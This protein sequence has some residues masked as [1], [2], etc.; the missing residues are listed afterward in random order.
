MKNAVRLLSM[1]ALA[2][3][4]GVMPAQAQFTLT[5]IAAAK[6]DADADYYPDR[7]TTVFQVTGRIVSPSFRT[8][9]L[10]I[11]I[12]D[13][14]NGVG[15]RVWYNVPDTPDVVVEDYVPGKQVVAKGVIGQSNGVRFIRAQF[16]SWVS[17][18]DPTI[19]PV[20]PLNRTLAQLAAA[21]EDHEGSLVLVSNCWVS[22]GSLPAWQG[23]GTLTVTDLTG[24]VTLYIDADLDLDGQATP[25]ESFDLLGV[26]A[27]YDN[28]TPPDGG[29]QIYP[30]YY[31]DFILSTGDHTPAVS[32][33]NS[34]LYSIASGESLTV[35]VIG[36]DLDAADTLTL[37]L[38]QGPEGASFTDYGNRE[39]R[40]AW[41]PGAGDRGIVTGAVFEVTDGTSTGTASIVIT[42]LDEIQANIVLN[43]VHWDPANGLDGDA[44]GDGVRDAKY[45]EFIEILN[46]NTQA[47][48][49]TGWVLRL[50]E[51]A[52]LFTFP[53]CI[54]SAQSAVV[55]FGGG[56]NL[57][58]AFGQATVFST[59][60]TPGLS[61]KP[62]DRRLTLHDDGGIQIFSE[63]YRSFG[64]PNQSITRNPDGTGEFEEHLTANPMLRFSPGTK[65]DGGYFPGTGVTNAPPILA[66]IENQSAS[67][68]GVLTVGIVGA[69]PEEQPVTLSVTGAPSTAVLLDAGDGTGT[70]VYTGQVADAGLSFTVTVTIADAQNETAQ[71]FM[72][73]VTS[74]AYSGLVINEYLIDPSASGVYIDSNSDGVT[75][76][77]DDEFIEIMNTGSSAVDF[78]GLMIYDGVGLRHRFEARQVP[79]G[80]AIVVFGGGSIA[81]FSNSPA[82]LASSGSLGLNNGSDSIVL[83][84]PST[85]QIDRVDYT[86]SE[87]DQGV[88]A[89]R[90]PD[91]TG[92]WESNHYVASGFTLRASPGLKLTGAAFLTNQPPVLGTPGDQ[93]AYVGSTLAFQ[94]NASDGDGHAITLAAS[95]LPANA[96]FFPT[97]GAGQA[98]GTFVFTPDGTQEGST[99]TVTF[100]AADTNGVSSVTVTI[101]V[102]DALAAFEWPFE[103]GWQGWTNYSRASDKDWERLDGTGAESTTYFMFANGYSADVAS[104]DWLISPVLDLTGF[105]DPYLAFQSYRRY[106]G[107]DIELKV[108]TDYGGAGDPASATWTT[109][110]FT[111]PAS[112]QVWTPTEHVGL[113]DYVSAATYIAFH[114][115]STG[116]GSGDAEWWQIDQV[117]VIDVDPNQP[118]VTITNPATS[119]AEVANAVSA[120]TLQGVAG[121]ASGHLRWLCD[122]SGDEDIVPVSGTW[123]IPSI[124]LD[125]G[126]NVISVTVSNAAG[127]T[128]SD[129]VT[130]VRAQ[131]G[132]VL[133]APIMLTP[134]NVDSNRFQANWAAVDYATG[135]RLDVA[136]NAAFAVAGVAYG[137][138]DG[139]E[140]SPY[141]VT[142]A[143]ALPTGVT[144]Y[145]AWGYVVGGRYDDF[146]TPW[147]NDY[148]ISVAGTD[149][150]TVFD[151]CLQVKLEDDGGRATWGLNSNPGNYQKLIKFKGY[152]DSYG[153]SDSFEGVD[154]SDI[155]EVAAGGGGSDFVHGYQDRDVGNVTLALVTGLVEGVTYY[156][157]VRAE[158]AMTVS[159]NSTVTSVVA[160][161]SGGGYHD[162][163]PTDWW[164]RYNLSLT[165]TATGD[166]DGD[167]TSNREEYIADTNPTNGGSSF[168]GVITNVARAGI[169]LQLRV[170]PPTSTNR[171][172]DAWWRSNLILGA[173]WA[174]FNLNVPGR[175][176]GEALLLD[177]PNTV[178]G[179]FYRTGVKVNP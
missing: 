6:A 146:A 15:L 171:Y 87:W 157:R 57:T 81:A 24:E 34:N 80:G 124:G 166:V 161:A 19:A 70:L 67:V 172:Y 29:Y 165:N 115:T 139:T 162:G 144:E 78:D 44:D 59:N 143:K 132:E 41:T 111:N 5:N 149:S 175:A 159:P 125:V 69:D 137:D 108:S 142:Q 58:G 1:G 2:W 119:P 76:D 75:N 42:V 154:N 94:V 116:T 71:T 96:A 12:A 33:A 86:E 47:V 122:P 32:I 25:A 112:E 158:N 114:Y 123:T 9:D 66:R 152:R 60:W 176:D 134:S 129:T 88:S 107:P 65:L 126:T 155:S 169:A 85:S 23:G 133:E 140:G 153:G 8:N 138:G 28:S 84:S 14:T 11:F 131:P 35:Y 55:V 62:G 151:N 174:P 36:Q 49:V 68:G 147:D 74:E 48:D 179:G 52:T 16:G 163:I 164:Q 106:S 38:A 160:V 4:C 63:S 17:I 148:A 53:S 77:F 167:G 178:T 10:D 135:Y 168:S 91:G 113:S 173:D 177:I 89:T 100:Y 18:S 22:Q 61:N 141:S 79:A 7:T 26:Y 145:W 117:R 27:Q 43:E 101:D 20:T 121:N 73:E 110:T 56:T 45:D 128:A 72:L 104:D 109:L 46:N 21:P 90:N 170:G 13:P 82:Q 40:F 51:N 97:N 156:V 50:G 30:R 54:V 83:Y 102:E 127:S 37:T 98:R 103:T 105:A 130:I 3:V 31:S 118:S 99:N 92:L 150:E 120:Y 95:N 136:T 64:E 39:G 93:V